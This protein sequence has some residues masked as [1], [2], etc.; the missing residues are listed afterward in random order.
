MIVLPNSHLLVVAP[1]PDDEVIGCGGL[2]Q[3]VLAMDGQVTVIIMSDGAASHPGSDSYPPERLV[4]IR[5]IESYAGLS[6]LGV[7]RSQIHMLGLPDGRSDEWSEFGE[8]GKL[9]DKAYDLIALPSPV[10]N[11]PD[12]RATYTIIMARLRRTPAMRV[13]TYIVWPMDDG[14]Q[15]SGTRHTLDLSAL[16][17]RKVDALHHY[18][19]QLGEITDSP[20]GFA[21]DAVLFDRFTSGPEIFYE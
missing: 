12:H 18:R 11:H 20:S 1:H 3:Q 7:D 6:H 14:T 17:K 9:L 21:I 16:K 8:L 15:P 13:L 4:A 10:D 5:A 19:S 2:I